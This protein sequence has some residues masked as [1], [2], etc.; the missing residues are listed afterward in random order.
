M[1]PGQQNRQH[2]RQEGGIPQGGYGSNDG[3]GR[4][5]HRGGYVAQ[6]GNSRQGQQNHYREQDRYGGQEGYGSQGSYGR[7]EEYEREQGYASQ[8]GSQ[9]SYGRQDG[10]GYSRPDGPP[11]SNRPQ[12]SGNG[13][14]SRPDGP[15]PSG[16][17]QQGGNEGYS[18]PDGPPPSSGGGNHPQYT[19]P[20]SNSQS[21][22][23]GGY[24]YQYSQC[25]GKKKA[26]LV[27]INYIGTKQQ[28]NGCINDCNNVKQYLL[29]QGFKQDDMVMLNDQNNSVRAIPTR[30]NIIDAIQ[31]LVKD[32][33]A[34]DSL[35]FHYSGHGGQ[36][37][38][39]NG[40]EIDGYDEV[41]YPLDFETAGYIDDDTLHQL[42]VNNL[43]KGA[44][45][46][47]LFDSCHSGSVLDLPYMYSTKGIIKEPNL[48]EE[49]GE[50]L[51]EAAKAYTKG[52]NKGVLS[53]IMGVAK[54]IMNKDRASE[55]NELT[56]KTKTSPADVISLSGCKDDQT[57]AD[58]K[59]AGQSTGAMSFAFLSVLKQEPQQS[60][61]SLLQN[62]RSILQSKYSQ[63]PQLSSSHPIDTNLQFII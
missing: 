13:G 6:E 35:V 28:L 21:F 29:T 1:F 34:N 22:G 48:L 15:P 12:Q 9:E 51:L 52:D 33:Q 32:A 5:D 8:Q 17:P 36:T 63:K 2:G 55:A 62:M 25:N 26:L 14:Y 59:E 50:G 56:K 45:L 18:R 44:R 61:L 24:Q 19:R 60:Y 40:D 54:T 3:Y 23:V 58:A 41:I 4:E 10:G 57:S 38:D 42:L 47:A 37:E 46:T 31:W 43:P 39:K 20:S 30:Q 7:P 49:A 11:P 16:R 27:G 53:G